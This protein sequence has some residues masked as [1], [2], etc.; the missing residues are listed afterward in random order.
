[1]LAFTFAAAELAIMLGPS[2]IRIAG[3]LALGCLPGM[4]ITRV[5][6][7]RTRFDRT[8]QLL[9]VPGMSLAVAI[10]T[11]LVL[12]TADIRL[13]TGNWAIALGLVTAAGFV[14][15]AML[16][17]EHEVGRHRRRRRAW[18]SAAA[19]GGRRSLGIAPAA[20]FV[21]GALAVTAA[22]AIGVLG[23][24]DRDSG[25]EFTQLWALPG[26]GSASA[27]RLGVR[28]H[29][30]SDVHYRIR[31]SVEGRVVRNQALTL[32]PGQTW[33]ST[34]PVARSGARVDVALLAS[35]RDPAYRA[36]HLTAG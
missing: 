25:T 3:G 34:Q 33:Q 31:V 7:T 26:S 30:R 9:L 24:R 16:E 12:N 1:M 4:L 32:R 22:V 21:M 36:V 15:G 17:D 10:I 18:L 20:M 13:T 23:Q 27:V 5:I 8:E 6:Q 19:P 2:P 14:A 11:G 28:S 29:E 35:P